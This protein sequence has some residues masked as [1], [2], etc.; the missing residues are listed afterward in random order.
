MSSV[1]HYRQIWAPPI[2]HHSLSLSLFL[3]L[4]LFLSLMSR[5]RFFYIQRST[6]RMDVNMVRNLIVAY[7][8]TL[9]LVYLIFDLFQGKKCTG[10]IIPHTKTICG[11]GKE[12]QG[13]RKRERLAVL[14][15]TDIIK[16]GGLTISCTEK[17]MN[18]D[19]EVMGT[20]LP[21]NQP[22][23]PFTQPPASSWTHL[24]HRITPTFHSYSSPV[25]HIVLRCMFYL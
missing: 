8:I 25:L 20:Q 21:L 4:H 17:F 11:R 22:S 14:T 2:I 12:K 7:N 18:V 5:F 24:H 9:A 23:A 13:E 16:Q 10:F 1:I 15:K 6:C 3:Y 19:T